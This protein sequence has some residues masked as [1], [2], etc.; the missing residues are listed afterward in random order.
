MVVDRKNSPPSGRS[1]H[2]PRFNNFNKI[3]LYWGASDNLLKS[4]SHSDHD[5]GVHQQVPLDGGGERGFCTEERPSPPL[6]SWNGDPPGV[7]R[8]PLF[9]GISNNCEPEWQYGGQYP[10][11]R[12][13]IE[14]DEALEWLDKILAKFLRSNPF[15]D[16]KRQISTKDLEFLFLIWE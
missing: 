2:R 12:R 5:R 10:R 6:P 11:I 16:F 8:A 4:N 3:Y 14:F 15:W 1:S 13:T 7:M 9:P